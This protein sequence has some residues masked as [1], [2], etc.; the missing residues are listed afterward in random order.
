MCSLRP[1]PCVAWLRDVD[2]ALR[3]LMLNFCK[4]LPS[5]CVL[6][7]TGQLPAGVWN[8]GAPGGVRTL[9]GSDQQDGVGLTRG[10]WSDLSRSRRLLRVLLKPL[11]LGFSGLAGG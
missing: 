2:R 3:S 7:T 11:A 1:V 5:K 10:L 8:R 4:S 9:C 6:W